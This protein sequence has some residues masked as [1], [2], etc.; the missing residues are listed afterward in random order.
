[1][2]SDGTTWSELTATQFTG[3]FTVT[4]LVN[5]GNYL[6]R[7]AALNRVGQGPWS[8]ASATPN[9][10]PGVPTSLIATAVSKGVRLTWTAPMS[11]ASSITGYRV[12]YFTGGA[13]YSLI[14]T[15][16]TPRPSYLAG[17]LVNGVQYVMRV[18]GINNVGLGACSGE[19][20]FSPQAQ[21][22][23]PLTL[24]AVPD[25]RQVTLYWAQP[26]LGV[27]SLIGDRV[28]R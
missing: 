6:F 14:T 8:V 5:G 7:V 22:S 19:V 26:A 16:G 13:W 9:A 24:R 2:S 20:R 28:Q 12:Q 4:G 21:A 27:G 17:N 23:A 18:C 15:T 10:V 3:S 25:D 1:M 11:G